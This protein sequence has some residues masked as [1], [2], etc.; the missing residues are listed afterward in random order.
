M[1]IQNFI[2][3]I[4]KFFT[5][6]LKNF[7]SFKNK[8]SN[9]KTKPF[10]LIYFF[11]YNSNFNTVY[12]LLN[13]KYLIQNNM[14]LILSYTLNRKNLNNKLSF[15]KIFKNYSFF[16]I[17]LTLNYKT[18]HINS[19]SNFFKKIYQVVSFLKFINFY[20]FKKIN[21]FFIR[22][23]RV[24]NKG[25]YSRNRQYYRTGVYW[26]LYIH[27]IAVIGIYFWFYKLTMNFNYFWL[28]LYLFVISFIWSRLINF[29]SLIKIKNLLN[30]NSTLILLLSNIIT[31]YIF[32]FFSKF[33][34]FFYQ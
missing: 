19:F 3:Y 16:T 27:I 18:V 14:L 22:K 13:K 33:Y 34:L 6:Y 21:I 10:K 30:W 11:R 26:C 32:F 2:I 23:F 5:I 15:F 8:S 20:Q 24:F 29:F 28:I 17:N 12:F 1:V 4:Y 9:L 25:R 31:R 7:F